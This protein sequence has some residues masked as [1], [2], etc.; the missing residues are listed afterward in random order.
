M[1]AMKK[2]A[3]L[4]DSAAR[5]SS[6]ARGRPAVNQ[7]P[8]RD[9]TWSLALEQIA[10]ERCRSSFAA[11]FRHFSPLLKGFLMK[12]SRL[13]AAQAEELVQEIMIKVWGRA[14]QFDSRKSSATTWL[15][16]IARNSR[17]DWLRRQA[18]AET[19]ELIADDL[20]EDEA[21][22]TP[23]VQLQQ[24]RH[25]R[26]VAQALAALPEEQALVLTK[27]YMESKSHSE[28]SDELGLPLGTVKSRVR[29][30]LKKLQDIVGREA[31]V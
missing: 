30:A 10:T 28:V 6:L 21:A 4:P 17:I 31:F 9:D 24:L 2:T 20:Y 13:N 5:I 18:N 1:M 22:E 14:S 25:E 29:L 19:D 8:Q 27:V 7:S 26:T 16:T 12:G 15:Y 3:D 11:F 23:F